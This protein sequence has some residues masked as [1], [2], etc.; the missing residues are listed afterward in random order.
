M[1]LESAKRP[2]PRPHHHPFVPLTLH[3]P[4]CLPGEGESNWGGRDPGAPQFHKLFP[5]DVFNAL[6][7]LLGLL[8]EAPALIE[9]GNPGLHLLLLV[10]PHL[11]PELV[12]ML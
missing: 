7:P 2:S 4:G 8:L 3:H 11:A 5:L 1:S 12:G 6:T 10:L 9:G